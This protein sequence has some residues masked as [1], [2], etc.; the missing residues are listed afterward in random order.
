MQSV[1]SILYVVNCRYLSIRVRRILCEK[2]STPQEAWDR[3]GWFQEW[4][5]SNPRPPTPDQLFED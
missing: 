1:V 4:M 2:P 3:W 5:D